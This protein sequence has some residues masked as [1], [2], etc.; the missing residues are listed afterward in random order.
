ME[1]TREMASNDGAKP[2]GR[3]PAEAWRAEKMAEAL[4]AALPKGWGFWN[5][6]GET[7]Q[8]VLVLASPPGGC[9]LTGFSGQSW[10]ICGCFGGDR[11]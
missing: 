4:K 9:H 8:T 2:H 11:G 7:A 1:R 5:P 10:T 6:V 3:Q